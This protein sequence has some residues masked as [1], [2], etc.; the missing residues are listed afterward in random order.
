MVS[1][2]SFVPQLRKLG[3]IFAASRTA[4]EFEGPVTMNVPAWRYPV[5]KTPKTM[6]QLHSNELTFSLPSFDAEIR[7]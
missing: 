2:Q 5:R 6:I 7:A 3:I 1:G 4:Q